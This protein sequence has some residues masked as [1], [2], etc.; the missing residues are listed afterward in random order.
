MITARRVFLRT[1]A[2]WL[3]LLTLAALALRLWRIDSR[4]L[5]PDEGS[6]LYYAQLPLTTLLWSLCDPHP[7]GYYLLLR[8]MAALGQGEAWLRLPSVLAGT[9]AVPLTWAVARAALRPTAQP[10]QRWPEQAA[11]LAAALVAVAPLAVWYS[12]E[13]RAYGALALL[14]LAMAWVA[15]RWRLQ[16]TRRTAAAFLLAGWLALAT[17]YGALV[18]L[19]GLNLFLLSGWPWQPVSDNRSGSSRQWLTLQAVLLTPFVLWW[20]ISAQPAALAQMSY[21]AIFLAVQAQR[22][23]LDWTPEVAQRVIV[24][25]G[26]AAAG[27]GL[28]VAIAVRR[29][30]RARRWLGSPWVAAALLAM[31]IALA[32]LGALPRL[33]TVKRHLNAL[34]PFVSI[35]AAWALWRVRGSV[36]R[37]SLAQ[38]GAAGATV[39]VLLALSV[40]LLLAAPQPAWPQV[41]DILAE[42]LQDED[43]LWVDEQD[44]TVF[45]YY[46]QAS[47]PWQPLRARDLDVLN[48]AADEQRVWLVGGVSAYR[49]LRQTLPPAFASQR[50]AVQSF[51]WGD[52]ALTAYDWSAEPQ[53]TADP[54][55]ALRW[56]LASQSPLDVVCPP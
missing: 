19:F 32:L 40:A 27:L 24:L 49:D 4:A 3:A 55:L 33:Y 42:H 18:I 21:Q 48:Q 52:V 28:A 12:Q 25:A 50:A 35:A 22:L 30:P 26:L 11:L 54:P 1:D 17:E 41:V 23:G 10:D 36:S 9:L 46:W 34:L 53:P 14:A 7:P 5:L 43:A 38:R 45:A 8:G 51:V 44:A 16:P 39:G 56:G 31:V 15:L 13:A 2:L 6:S 47:A 29:S 37:P 20:L